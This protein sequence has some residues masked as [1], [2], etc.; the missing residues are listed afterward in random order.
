MDTNESITK[1]ELWSN[2]IQDFQESGLTCKC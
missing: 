1:D 2:R